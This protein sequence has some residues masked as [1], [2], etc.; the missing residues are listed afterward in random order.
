M[1]L[2]DFLILLFAAGLFS[3]AL[4]FAVLRR[5]P[6]MAALAAALLVGMAWNMIV[7]VL[8]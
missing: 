8:R 5:N 6:V 1:T 7:G 3:A 4:M 2:A